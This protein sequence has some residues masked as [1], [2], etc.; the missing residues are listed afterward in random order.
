MKRRFFARFAILAALGLLIFSLNSCYVPSPLYGNWTDNAGNS[1][2]FQSDAAFSAKIKTSTGSN[3]YQGTYVVNENVLVFEVEKPSYNVVSE[4]DV[5]G[6]M[7]YLVWKDSGGES[8][9]LTLYF[10]S[11]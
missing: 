9:L 10:T 3:S 7:L 11:K 8:V 6:S 1:I 2:R 4:W 5:R